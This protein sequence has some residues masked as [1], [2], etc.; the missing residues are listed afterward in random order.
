MR[1][2]I[3]RHEDRTQDATMFSP[4]TEEGLENSIKLINDLEDLDIDKIYS[5]PFIR[6]LQTVY[7]YANKKDI[8]INAAVS[9]TEE[10]K[11]L[12]FVDELNTQN[13]LEANHLLFLKNHHN[14]KN[15][16]ISKLKIRTKRLDKIL[17]SYNYNDID[18]MNIDVEG[19]ELNILNSIDFLKYK[20]KFICIEMIDHNDQAKLINEK[21]N[22]ILERNGY[23]L[24]KKIDF[25][26]I[27]KKN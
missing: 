27:F 7:P 1:I 12:Y 8:N 15:E 18:F 13:T 25:N 10:N 5:S 20:I 24:E 9:D 22:E 16:E 26:F 14:L 19:H 11:T 6:T 3:L 4:L 17:D 2:Y 21:L 23:I